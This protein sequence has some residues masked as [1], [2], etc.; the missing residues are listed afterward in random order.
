MVGHLAGRNRVGAE[1]RVFVVLV[2]VVIVVFDH[3]LKLNWIRWLLIG[4]HLKLRC[5]DAFY[6]L[7][8]EIVCF[9]FHLISFF[10]DL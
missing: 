2:V 10:N 9:S 3:T 5:T 4:Y 6:D 7:D 1:Y 8:V